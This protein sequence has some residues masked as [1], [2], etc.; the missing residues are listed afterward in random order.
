MK[1]A[2]SALQEEE[3]VPRYLPVV[4]PNGENRFFG[5]E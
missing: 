1:E 2:G 3:E 4:V 5:Y